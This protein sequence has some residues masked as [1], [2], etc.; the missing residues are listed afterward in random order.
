MFAKRPTSQELLECSPVSR[1]WDTHSIY[2]ISSRAALRGWTFISSSK[3][4]STELF[5]STLL[6]LIGGANW[7]LLG[8]IPSCRV[9]GSSVEPE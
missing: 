6:G 5:H 2:F 9:R 3:S 4:T 7:E 8:W 1:L